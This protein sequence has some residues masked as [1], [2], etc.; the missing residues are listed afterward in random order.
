MT[1]ETPT[2]DLPE[3]PPSAPKPLFVL[4][5]GE[6]G[7]RFAPTSHAEVREWLE[8]ETSLWSTISAQHGGVQAAKLYRV[9]HAL[10]SLRDARAAIDEADPAR[11]QAIN[12]NRNPLDRCKS[13]IEA[14]FVSNRLPHSSTPIYRRLHALAAQDSIA[15]SFYASVQ[16]PVVSGEGA[17]PLPTEV[18][19]WRGYVEGLIDRYELGGE[20][21]AKSVLAR[22]E[23]FDAIRGKLEGLH[24]EHSKG[25]EALD[26]HFEQTVF[27]IRKAR[28]AQTESFKLSQAERDQ[29]FETLKDKHTK[30]MAAIR[31]SFRVGQG[32]RAPV[33]YWRR[34]QVQHGRAVTA[35]GYAVGVGMA[36]SLFLLIWLAISVLADVPAGTPP[37]LWKI[38]TL[39]LTTLFA[40][41]GM[42]ILVRMLLSNLHLR[43]D[44]EERAVMVETYLALIEGGQVTEKEG[45][46]LILSALFRPAADGIVKDEGMPLNLFEILTRTSKP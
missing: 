18:R 1:D 2:A 41:W 38:A 23:A 3:L 25:L 13:Q 40:L 42:R 28:I 35:F 30:E 37:A 31:E 7:G 44:A 26:R 36:F 16:F 15:A 43:T 5:L 11:R 12:G 27:A 29:D 4:D 20:S 39:S 19:G 32:M 46:E 9:E 6:N 14:A 24:A 22:Q 17:R 33:E 10:A 8:R 21:L 45:R 34:K